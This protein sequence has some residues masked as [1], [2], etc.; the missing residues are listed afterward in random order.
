MAHKP[1]LELSGILTGI[2]A[3]TGKPYG[4]YIYQKTR[5]GHG[6]IHGDTTKRQ[7]VRIWVRGTNPNTPAQQPYR[8][9]FALGVAAWH[10]LIPEEKESWRA[11][12]IAL[13][14]NR[15][16]A[17]MRDYLRTQPVP[18]GTEWDG[19][20]TTWDSGTTTWDM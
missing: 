5:A 9:R 6:N 7:Q 19:G 4:K 12:G 13:K 10:K 14:L 8:A 11:P 1:H 3:N 18:V 2:P 15:F 16:Q 17:F 20:T